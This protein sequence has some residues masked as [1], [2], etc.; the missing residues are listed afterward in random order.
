MKGFELPRNDFCGC[1]NGRET[2]N[3]SKI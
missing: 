1:R 2:I 3:R